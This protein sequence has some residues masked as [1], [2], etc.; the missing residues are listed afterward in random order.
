MFSMPFTKHTSANALP[1]PYSLALSSYGKSSKVLNSLSDRGCGKGFV[2]PLFICDSLNRSRQSVTKGFVS[3]IRT[4]CLSCLYAFAD[5]IVFKRSRL[6]Q[7]N[8]IEF[9]MAYH[10]AG[11]I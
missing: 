3:T 1:M 5:N 11:S 10:S 4:S 6:G 7:K 9:K 2:D 8:T